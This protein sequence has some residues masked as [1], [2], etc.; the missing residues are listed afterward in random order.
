MG[1]FSFMCK[2][3][4]EQVTSTSFDGE[5]VKLFLLKDGE[6][7]EKME[8]PYDSYGRVFDENYE[9]IKWEMDWLEVCKLNFDTD[10]SNGI[11]GVHARCWTKKIPR[12]RSGR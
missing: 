7:I 9:S 12:L 1:C 4:G 3:C 5:M 11:A 8:G 10:K 6:V 2:E